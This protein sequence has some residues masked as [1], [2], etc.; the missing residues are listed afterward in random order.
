MIKEFKGADRMAYIRITNKQEQLQQVDKPDV[1]KV[2]KYY[3]FATDWFLYSV[4]CRQCGLQFPTKE[5]LEQHKC[6]L[7][8]DSYKIYQNF[9]VD[10]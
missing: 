8:L 9:K 7:T 10:K 2:Y 1:I 5:K 6:N 4:G 3:S